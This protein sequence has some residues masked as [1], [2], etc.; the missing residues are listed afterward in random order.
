MMVYHLHDKL[1]AAHRS[2][3]PHL[4]Q[5]GQTELMVIPRCWSKGLAASFWVAAFSMALVKQSAQYQLQQSPSTALPKTASTSRTAAD[6]RASARW[7]PMAPDLW[8]STI[9]TSLSPEP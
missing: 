3:G 2:Q 9:R 1:T 7:H 6:M 4:H 8:G 5:P